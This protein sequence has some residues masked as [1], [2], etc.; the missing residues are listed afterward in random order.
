MR[1]KKLK[2]YSIYLTVFFAL[3]ALPSKGSGAL[4]G[5]K[6]EGGLRFGVSFPAELGPSG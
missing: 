5:L 4:Q 6:A 1:Q 2:K 3:L